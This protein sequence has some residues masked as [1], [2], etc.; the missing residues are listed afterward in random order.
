MSLNS[1]ATPIWNEIAETQELKT[2]W[3]RKAFSLDH[4]E[5]VQLVEKEYAE[6]LERT[7]HEVA[8]AILDMK[9][10]LLENVAI[11]RHI[12]R[13]DNYQLRTALPEVTTIDEAVML[14]TE[15]D[16]LT[17]SQQRQLRNLLEK[18]LTSPQR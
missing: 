8:K 12:Q 10:L 14:A 9:P 13:T 5:Q 11:S 1:I 2:E 17:A 4:E 6:L 3:A 7:S 15:E 16:N 18:E